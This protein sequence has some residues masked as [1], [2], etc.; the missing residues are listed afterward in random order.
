MV[1][2]ASISNNIQNPATP[3]EIFNLARII[4][5]KLKRGKRII[6]I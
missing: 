3:Q 1:G 4:S 6:R 2:K 5:N